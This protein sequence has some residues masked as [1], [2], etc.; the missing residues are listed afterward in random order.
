MP[1]GSSTTSSTFCEL[2]Q[3]QLVC[4][5]FTALLQS[6]FLISFVVSD[7]SLILVSCRRRSLQFLTMQFPIVSF[8]ISC[9]SCTDSLFRV[10]GRASNTYCHTFKYRGLIEYEHPAAARTRE[11]PSGRACETDT[12]RHCDLDTRTMAAEDGWSNAAV[13]PSLQYV[14]SYISE[15]LCSVPVR[16]KVWSG[17]DCCSPTHTVVCQ[18]PG[19]TILGEC[20]YEP[21][22]RYTSIMLQYER[23]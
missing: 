1:Y 7:S 22:Y 2:Q 3:L 23:Q 21:H 5:A 14:A 13:V 8:I 20:V 15:S 19:C 9:L 18:E 6:G 10:Q 17:A 11:M 4:C 12:H 16:G